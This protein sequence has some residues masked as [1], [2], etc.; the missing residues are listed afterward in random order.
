MPASVITA[1]PNI[2]MSKTPF[3]TVIG[4][5]QVGLNYSFFT[6][7]ITLPGASAGQVVSFTFA[8]TTISFTMATT[9]D[10]SGTQLPTWTSGSLS[11]YIDTLITHFNYN[12]I[13]LD[14]FNLVNSGGTSLVLALK[15]PGV[16]AISATET[17]SNTTVVATN[18]TTP[19]FPVGLSAI[20][21]IYRQNVPSGETSLVSLNVPFDINTASA[22]FDL[23]RCFALEPHLPSTASMSILATNIATKAFNRYYFRYGERKGVPAVAGK[24][25]KGFEYSVIYGGKAGVNFGQYP[26]TSAIFS[27]HNYR[28]SDY[29][30][31]TKPVTKEQPDWLYFF[32][33]ITAS[34]G[35]L[36]YYRVIVTWSDGS[37]TTHDLAPL[38]FIDRTMYWISSGYTQLGLGALTP[39]SVGAEIISYACYIKESGTATTYLLGQFY[40]ECECNPWDTYLLMDNGVGGL[41]TVWCQ[42]KK[43]TIYSAERQT[44]RRVKWTDFDKSIGDM[45]P[46][47]SEGQTILEMNTGFHD[48]EYIQHLRQLL[49]GELWIVDNVN[50]VF[51]KCAI[52]TKSLEIIEDDQDLFSLNFTLK[53]ASYDAGAQFT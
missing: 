33:R 45:I 47:E 3:H 38:I 53:I 17:M 23:H 31:L 6:M 13:I 18:S 51:I 30:A 11:D 29:F 50:S 9:P 34:P 8:T 27:C 48:Q 44:A 21:K 43:K 36:Y 41:E 39:P 5:D 26:S 49:L 14:N 46:I 40:V 52:D 10:N 15:Q 24:M 25:T 2:G 7:T 42:G 19:V 1:P 28:K 32:V 4:T 12:E 22:T 20:L 35:Y 16:V 37:S